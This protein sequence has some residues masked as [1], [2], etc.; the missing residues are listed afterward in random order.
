MEDQSARTGVVGTK[1]DTSPT[2]RETELGPMTTRS[3]LQWKS[4]R[5]EEHVVPESYKKGVLADLTL[6]GIMSALREN[7]CKKHE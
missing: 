5:N 7:D 2:V 6:P 4:N 3:S 1:L